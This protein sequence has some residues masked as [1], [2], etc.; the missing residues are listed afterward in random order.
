MSGE[1]KGYVPEEEIGKVKE[2]FE[3]SEDDWGPS[4]NEL[5]KLGLSRQEILRCLVLITDHY[6]VAL[7]DKGAETPLT[8]E[9]GMMLSSLTQIQSE[10]IQ[11]I[12]L[13]GDPDLYE[14]TMD[15]R[16]NEFIFALQ[17]F[18]V[19]EN[20]FD[21]EMILQVRA[22]A[23]RIKDMPR[24][25]EEYDIET[26]RSEIGEEIARDNQADFWAE[27]ERRAGGI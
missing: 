24:Q 26:I 13:K 20:I 3:F 6:I 19:P 10:V 16:I 22:L 17:G 14:R 7:E 23:V 4:V 18:G 8:D 21:P 11:T 27:A 12:N 9:E 2:D 25:K 15:N 1:F 5:M